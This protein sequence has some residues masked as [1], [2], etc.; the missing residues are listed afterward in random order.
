MVVNESGIT[1]VG[2]RLLI[3]PLVIEEKSQGGIIIASST[4]DMERLAQMKG[5]VVEVG[6]TAYADQPEAWCKLGDLVTFGKYSG[7]IYKGEETL[8]KKEYRVVNDL[9]IVAIHKREV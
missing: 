3:K 2:H 8:D 9:D 4:L 1:P 6:S 5:V 7:L